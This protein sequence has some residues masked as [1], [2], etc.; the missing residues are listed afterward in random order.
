MTKIATILIGLTFLTSCIC[1][2]QVTGTIVD[3][4]TGRPL[5]GVTVYNK[6]IKWSKTTTD[7]TGKFELSNVSWGF[8]CPPM[9]VIAEF[10]NFNKVEVKIPVGGKEIIKMPFD[11]FQKDLAIEQK[12]KQEIQFGT[13]GIYADWS[14]YTELTIKE[15]QTFEYIDRGFTG[16]GYKNNGRWKIQNG[17]LLLYDYGENNLFS[18]MPTIWRI[19]ENELC[20]ITKKHKRKGLCIKLKK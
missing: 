17:K 11:T 2:Q 10:K 20:N 6:N 16:L 15:N 12:D 14:I 7:T 3:K 19:K 13:Y 4:E 5:Q 1:L 18:P 9:T 8:R